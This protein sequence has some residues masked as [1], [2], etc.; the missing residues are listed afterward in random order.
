MH[1]VLLL[2]RGVGRQRVPSLTLSYLLPQ[3][4]TAVPLGNVMQCTG[5]LQPFAC[6]GL[7]CLK[8]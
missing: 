8:F 6:T 5:A 2:G 3:A 7:P 1:T 4:D